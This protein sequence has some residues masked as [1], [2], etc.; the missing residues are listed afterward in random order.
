MKN[1]LE[2]AVKAGI[3]R[4][5]RR[6]GNTTRMIDLAVQILFT[7]GAVEI[8]CHAMPEKGKAFEKIHFAEQVQ[9]RIKSEHPQWIA[10]VSD[11]GKVGGS[12]FLTLRGF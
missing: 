6:Q 3:I 12:I 1:L 2:E 9:R 4:E 10:D 7:D 11:T 5:G 8:D